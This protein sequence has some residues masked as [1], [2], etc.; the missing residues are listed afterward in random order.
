M[1]YSKPVTVVIVGVA[2]SLLTNIVSLIIT[3][4]L[5]VDQISMKQIEKIIND[6]ATPKPDS[7]HHNISIDVPRVEWP[8]HAVIF[9]IFVMTLYWYFFGK[10][11]HTLTKDN[12]WYSSFLVITINCILFGDIYVPIYWGSCYLG[13]KN[14]RDKVKTISTG[15]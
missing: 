12:S 14:R 15:S 11:V 5:F 2:I 3:Y 4:E 6:P 9:L 7:T 1:K 10:I 13:G 8:W